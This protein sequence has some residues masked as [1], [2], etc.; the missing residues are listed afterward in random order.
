MVCRKRDKWWPAYDCLLEQEIMFRILAHVLPAD[1]PQQAET[2]S[3][4]GV[5]GH[6]NCRYDLSGGSDAYRETDEGY[7]AHFSVMSADQKNSLTL[8]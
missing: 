1:N 8:H 2:A 4:I 5:K 7:H 3:T 6:Y